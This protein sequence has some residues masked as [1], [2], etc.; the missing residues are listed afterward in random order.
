MRKPPAWVSGVKP[1]PA[2]AELGKLRQEIAADKLHQRGTGHLPADREQARIEMSEEQRVQ[3]AS[4][5]RT[6][7]WKGL[8]KLDEKVDRLTLKHSQALLRLQEAEERLRQAPEDDAR[9]LAGW[10]AGGERGPRPAAT[11]YERERDRDAARLLGEAVALELDQALEARLQYVQRNRKKM[12]DDAHRDVA[13]A[14][15][16]L[17]AQVHG[18]PALRDALLA[19][20]ETLLWAAS[21]PEPVESYGSP[22]ALALGLKAPVE[23]TL[24]TSAR[25]EFGNLIG[26]LEEDAAALAESHSKTAKQQLGIVGPRTPLDQA[27]WDSDPDMAAWKKEELERARQLAEWHDSDKLAREIR[28]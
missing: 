4:R 17:L 5:P 12:L 19:A 8:V 21:F 7:R 11:V 3:R 22:G 20:R 1:D 14:R 18:L 9:T 2:E 28:G 10:L 15:E 16:R 24:G 27:M 6:R 26:A 25:I 13:E 23:K